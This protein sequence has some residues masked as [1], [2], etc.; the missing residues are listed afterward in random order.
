MPDAVGAGG[1]SV[2]VV[3]TVAD[4]VGNWSTGYPR[5]SPKY[6]GLPPHLAYAT[7]EGRTGGKR[8]RWVHIELAIGNSL[9][10]LDVGKMEFR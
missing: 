10:M 9:M 3:G 6:P 1:A 2:Q 7:A 8:D 5:K 4:F